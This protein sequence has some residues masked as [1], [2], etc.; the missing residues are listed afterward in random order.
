[1][2][3]LTKHLITFLRP[4]RRPTYSLL[5]LLHEWQDRCHIRRQLTNLSDHYLRDVG[6]TPYDVE[7]VIS[8]RVNKNAVKSLGDLARDQ[9]ANW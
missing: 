4:A 3:I 7:A 9:S 8:A 6:L 1:M 2:T 5:G